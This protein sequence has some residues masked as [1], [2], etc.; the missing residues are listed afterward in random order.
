MSLTK[1]LIKKIEKNGKKSTNQDYIK[2]I[3]SKVEDH[4]NAEIKKINECKKQL[5]IEIDMETKISNIKSKEL[6]LLKN[7]DE[8][9]DIKVKVE[10][11]DLI[12]EELVQLKLKLNDQINEFKNI[13]DF[14]EPTVFII[15]NYYKYLF[16]F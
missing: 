8:L 12:K 10:K 14:D 16:T 7:Q 5:F 15:I 6:V 11:N 4:H 2:S 3:K 1:I 9:K 13:V